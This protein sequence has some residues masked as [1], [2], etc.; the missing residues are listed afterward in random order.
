MPHDVYSDLLDKLSQ[1]SN[2]GQFLLLGDMNA[3]TQTMADFI[4]NENNDH[5]PTPPP[6]LYE[7]DTVETR[8]R[9]NMDKGF[10]S[11]GPKLID[12]CK[13]VPL[14]ILNGRVLGDL[15]GKYTCFTP[16]GNSTV[17]YAAVSPRLFKSVRYFSISSLLPHLSDHSPIQLAVKINFVI[18]N[19][20]SNYTLFPKPKKVV[21]DRQLSDKFKFILESP[22]CKE[23]FSNFVKTGI[24][25]NQP[26]LDSAV[27]FVTNVL[28]KTAENAGM[29]V[30]LSAIP[31]GAIPR[32]SARAHSGS[33]KRKLYPKWHDLEC[34]T[35]LANL[36]KTSKLLSSDL[37]NPWLKGKLSQESKLYKR[38]VK[39]K[40][41]LFT[42]NLFLQLQSMHGSDPKKYM[43]L[44]NSLRNGNFDRAKK[45]D[46]QAVE[47]DEWFD[48]FSSLLGKNVQPSESEVEMERFF[49]ENVDSFQTE[50]DHPF[51]KSFFLNQLKP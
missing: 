50:L 40:Q 24:M 27:D 46:S 41:K 36:K 26:S 9:N 22:D 30:N 14:R 16:R 38:L 51:S 12:L 39:H 10:N 49:N 48:H 18:T 47:P 23:T 34:H 2:D 21:W 13:T 37:R 7:M 17:D 25:P 29:T 15:F 44:V 4:T 5:I 3:R 1:C 11:Y 8:C 45:S 43:D 42:D 35:L 33:C 32:R 6:E 28:V 20:Q 19:K 31:K